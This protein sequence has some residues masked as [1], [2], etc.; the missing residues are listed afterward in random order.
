VVQFKRGG[1]WSTRIVPGSFR[2][3]I[4]DGELPEAMAIRAVDRVGNA[5]AAASVSLRK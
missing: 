2:S 4:L 1:K 5:S 3:L